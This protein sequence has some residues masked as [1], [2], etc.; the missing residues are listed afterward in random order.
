MN[1]WLR[2]IRGALGMDL[3]W[4]AGWAAVGM[5]MEF[6]D[7]GGRIADIWPAVLG[8]PGLLGGVA[9]S[10]VLG[11][12]AGRR[13]FDELSLPRFGV[14]G[15]LAGVLLGLLPL[16]ISERISTASVQRFRPDRGPVADNF[17]HSLHHLRRVIANSDHR[18]C[19]SHVRLE[20]HGVE[21]LLASPLREFREERDIAAKQRLEARPEGTEHRP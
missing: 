6:V 9:F 17:R 13:R 18:V 8:L 4:G 14:L 1:T 11:I 20:Q 16:A 19:T 12:A 2:R 7:P 15:A 10:V 3:T 5:L 21:R